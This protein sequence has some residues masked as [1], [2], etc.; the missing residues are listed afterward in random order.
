MGLGLERVRTLAVRR[1]V[2]LRDVRLRDIRNPAVLAVRRLNH[3]VRV[4]D[5]RV[6]HHNRSWLTRQI[7][8]RVGQCLRIRVGRTTHGTTALGENLLGDSLPLLGF[9]AAHE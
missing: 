7:G 3:G 8:Q 2:R 9:L 6:G 4:L 1:V 5:V